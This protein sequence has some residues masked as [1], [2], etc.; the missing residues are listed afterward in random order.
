MRAN[1]NLCQQFLL[2]GLDFGNEVMVSDR[3][4]L[5]SQISQSVR[6]SKFIL[7]LDNAP[8]LRAREI[9][10]QG[11]NKPLR[12]DP[13]ATQDMRAAGNISQL[14]S[15]MIPQD[16]I[17]LSDPSCKEAGFLLHFTS[18]NIAVLPAEAK[19]MLRLLANQLFPLLLKTFYPGSVTVDIPI[20][21]DR[22]EDVSDYIDRIRNRSA[23]FL[24]LLGGT[25]SSPVLRLIATCD[26]EK[27]SRQ[28]C[29]SFL[30]DLVSECGKITTI[31]GIGRKGLR[32][33]E[34]QIQKEDL[35]D[36]N[37]SSGT[38]P[39]SSGPQRIS[40][41]ASIYASSV[42]QNQEPTVAVPS[43]QSASSYLYQG[44]LD[45]DFEDDDFE[46]D[47]EEE[48]IPK[49]S[50]WKKRKEKS[51]KNK[52]EQDFSEDIGGE[53][54]ARKRSPI[55]SFLLFIFILIFL[56]SVGY[57]G[58]YYWKSAQNRSTYQS[59]REVYDN[60]GFLAPAGYPSGY[61][62]DFA[63]L[64]EINPDIVG[65][66]NI[67]GTGLDYPVVQTTDNTKYYR[68]NFERCV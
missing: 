59:L 11:F 12:Q 44:D 21:S 4:Q 61:D 68:M 16:A 15:A 24:P 17:P 3:Q 55:I 29:D 20:R 32:A 40:R 39:A 43:Y 19:T 50:R 34:K 48:D 64:W 66:I 42:T 2:L 46:D 65:W 31:S 49:K 63:G 35:S 47:F 56:G 26:S 33:V 52:W 1:P 23:D 37:F 10:A 53:A 5:I 60:P 6:D 8:V 28:C 67:D 7:I 58:Y 41:S 36:L 22:Q 57:L 27:R 25:S 54:V 14:Q 9:L 13:K 62:K 18:T 30:E 38:V 45:D 51:S